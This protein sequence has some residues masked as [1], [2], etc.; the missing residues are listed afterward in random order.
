MNSQ[1]PACGRT[2][3][4]RNAV[5]TCSNCGTACCERCSGAIV[6]EPGA[7]VHS[8]VNRVMPMPL[9]TCFRCIR[10]PL[11]S[12]EYTTDNTP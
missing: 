10:I 9:F 6:Y 7:I 4:W 8:M 11:D 5:G 2:V 12:T 1:C 3:S